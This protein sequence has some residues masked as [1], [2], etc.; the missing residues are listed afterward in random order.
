MFVFHSTFDVGCSMFD[1]HLFLPVAKFLNP[2]IP[3][4]IPYISLIMAMIWSSPNPFRLSA[5]DL[6]EATQSPHPLHNA[7]FTSILPANGPFV[8]AE[9]AE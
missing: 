8:M 7:G 9:G 6:Q 5:P 4:S 2:P 1:V 3:K